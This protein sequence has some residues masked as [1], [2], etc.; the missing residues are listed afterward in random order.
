MADQPDRNNLEP[1]R[2]RLRR[3]GLGLALAALAF[4]LLYWLRRALT[5]VFVS[6]LLAYLL[7][8]VVHRLERLR[9]NRSVA[10]FILAGVT[11]AIVAAAGTFLLIQTQQEVVQLSADL[12]HYLERLRIEAE[13]FTRKY[14][15][16]NLPKSFDE[17]LQGLS[18]QLSQ[19][20]PGTIMP[21]S[22][23]FGRII[24]VVSAGTV[25][26]AAWVVGLLVIPV[27]LYYLL[28]DWDVLLQ[29]T[30][31][32]IPLRFRAY[33]VDKADQID[34]VLGA[35]IRGQLT[36]CLILGLLYSLGLSLLGVNLAIIIGLVSGAAFIVP[37]LGTILGIVAASLMAL[38]EFGA[39][40]HLL[41]V[42]AVFGA[43]QALEGAV[44]TPRIT[45]KKVGLS[46]VMVILALLI[47]GRLLGFLGI[48]IA[49]PAAAVLKVFMKDALARYRLSEFFLKK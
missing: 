31:E 27:L 5:P 47:G 21:A 1:G 26:V 24:G 41:G 19:A 7:D 46:P 29:W 8:P 3:I 44:L 13:P 12:P 32:N 40:W 23:A 14:L 25:A 10:I 2:D 22:K 4:S 35:F 39:G 48:L 6:L 9:L 34:A 38:L 33:A 17:I 43:A 49:V 36:V 11:V 20:P 28:R 30:Q 37:Y 15:R 18:A 42:W 45:G 16:F